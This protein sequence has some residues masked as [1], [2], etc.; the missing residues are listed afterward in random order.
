MNQLNIAVN[1]SWKGKRH[2]TVCCFTN[3][4]DGTTTRDICDKLG[5]ATIQNTIRELD[6]AEHPG[7]ADMP[8]VITISAAAVAKAL[9]ENVD[10]FLLKTD[11]SVDCMLGI[12]PLPP[13]ADDN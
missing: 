13:T 6:S 8:R 12:H 10:V 3:L 7:S 2:T 1:A 9:G 5:P 11:A 4:P